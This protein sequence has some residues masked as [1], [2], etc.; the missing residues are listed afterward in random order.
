MFMKTVNEMIDVR[1]F[2]TNMFANYLNSFQM[3]N[4][5]CF[6]FNSVRYV[7]FLTFH[8]ILNQ[9]FYLNLHTRNPIL[10]RHYFFMFINFRKSYL[11]CNRKVTY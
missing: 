1:T 6:I 2:A 5:T 11:S 4:F 8:S 10:H 7:T 9:S 3:I